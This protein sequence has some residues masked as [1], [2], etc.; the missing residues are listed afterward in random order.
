[1]VIFM[2]VCYFQLITGTDILSRY[3]FVISYD[4]IG[5]SYIYNIYC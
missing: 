4:D 1:M 3:L 5:L 2:L